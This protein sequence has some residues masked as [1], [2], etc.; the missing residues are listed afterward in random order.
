MSI[1]FQKLTV[2]HVEHVFCWLKEPF[3]QEFWDNSVAFKDDILNFVQGRITQSNYAGGQ[4]V[5]WLAFFGEEP[6]A[7][8]MTILETTTSDINPE[9]ISCLSPTGNSYSLDFMIGNRNFVG[10]GLG[11][12][13]LEAFIAFFKKEVD[14]LASTFLID[15]DCANSKAVHVFA[16]AGF[17][18][19]CEF[20]MQGDCSG[21]GKLHCL[22]IKKI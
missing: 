19:I 9:K 1:P 12:P 16:K 22:M 13:T 3:V 7:L 10:K 6:F 21:Q 2:K 17:T 4:Y 14:H 15:P 8:I 5:Y 11:A 18:K 20:V